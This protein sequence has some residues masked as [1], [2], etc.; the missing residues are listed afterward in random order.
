MD[1]NLEKW[2][3][4]C[5]SKG[6]FRNKED[7]VEFCVGAVRAFCECLKIDSTKLPPTEGYQLP[8]KWSNLIDSELRLAH[9]MIHENKPFGFDKKGGPECPMP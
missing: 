5:I 2:L 7:A 6:T 8:L 3:E 4:E 1:E 9:Q